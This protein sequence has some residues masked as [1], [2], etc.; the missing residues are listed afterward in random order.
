MPETEQERGGWEK[1]WPQDGEQCPDCHHG[2]LEVQEFGQ[3]RGL[4]IQAW[5]A[6][7][8]GTKLEDADEDDEEGCGCGWSGSYH[9]NKENE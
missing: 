2:L 6:G 5:C 9:P 8:N 4:E 1:S 3:G 7:L